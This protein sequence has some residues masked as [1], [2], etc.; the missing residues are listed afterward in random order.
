MRLERKKRKRRN[1]MDTAIR[2]YLDKHPINYP[3]EIDTLMRH[4]TGGTH[5]T[6][7]WRMKNSFGADAQILRN[8]Q[9]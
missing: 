6:I 3:C 8:T 2:Q 7:P 1:K 9:I 5:S 4:F